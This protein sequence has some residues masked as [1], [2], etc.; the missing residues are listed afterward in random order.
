MYKRNH[1]LVLYKVFF[2]FIEI[3]DI[4]K[5]THFDKYVHK[6]KRVYWEIGSAK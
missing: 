6:K 5:L 3:E 2:V 1:K 4:Y